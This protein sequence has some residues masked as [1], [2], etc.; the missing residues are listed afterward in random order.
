MT[1]QTLTTMI[2]RLSAADHAR[3]ELRRICELFRT[4]HATMQDVVAAQQKLTKLEG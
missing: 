1:T 4:A 2:E 3:I